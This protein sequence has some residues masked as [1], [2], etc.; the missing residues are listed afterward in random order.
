MFIGTG[1]Y[2]FQ[3]SDVALLASIPRGT[4]IND[5]KFLERVKIVFKLVFKMLPNKNL[6]PN[7][8]LKK[9]NNKWKISQEKWEYFKRIFPFNKN[10]SSYFGK[11][12]HQKTCWLAHPSQPVMLLSVEFQSI[13]PHIIHAIGT[14]KDQNF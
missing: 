11:K 12:L 1:W 5:E 3:F 4:R 7:V 2:I 9:K 6:S 14:W 10:I 8:A 13:S